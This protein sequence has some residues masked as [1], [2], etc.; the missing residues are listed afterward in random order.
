MGASIAP[1]D[2]SAWGVRSLLPALGLAP[3]GGTAT[4][5]RS[6]RCAGR[7]P[8]R[9][10]SG[11]KKAAGVAAIA[12]LVGTP[13]A[14]RRRRH[15]M[16]RARPATRVLSQAKQRRATALAMREHTRL[17][18]ARSAESASLAGTALRVPVVAWHAPQAGMDLAARRRRHA[19]VAAN[20]VDTAARNPR[21]RTAMARARRG[22][23]VCAAPAMTLATARAAR[24]RLR[25][26][27]PERALDA[28][29]GST[30]PLMQDP[31]AQRA[32]RG[33]MR[34]R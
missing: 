20:R 30:R 21:H 12:L 13:S 14:A 19:P 26:W 8:A 24:G 31:T 25:H 22:D 9:P 23:S 7:R 33:I 1:Q 18:I 5:A 27:V 6:L 16:A 32:S 2:V 4:W 34:T 10:A 11:A 29:L 28:P 17:M 15:A 3:P